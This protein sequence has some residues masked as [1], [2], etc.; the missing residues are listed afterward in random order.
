[1]K[2]SF[3]FGTGENLQFAYFVSLCA[4]ADGGGE[5]L[6]ERDRFMNRKGERS[7]AGYPP[8]GWD[9]KTSALR[10]NILNL[11]CRYC[12][13]NYVGEYLHLESTGKPFLA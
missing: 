2:L 9:C 11:F 5:I 12:L 3:G 10:M 7:K 1:M 6:R 13:S 8:S 4:C